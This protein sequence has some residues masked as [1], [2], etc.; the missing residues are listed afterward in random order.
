[1][2]RHTAVASGD[3]EHDGEHGQSDRRTPLDHGKSAVG[4]V[5]GR[6]IGTAPESW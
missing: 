2:Y 1:M 6:S 5:T 4:R 3:N